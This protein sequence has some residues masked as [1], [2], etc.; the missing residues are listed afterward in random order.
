MNR[1]ETIEAIKVMQ[2]YADGGE[3][4]YRGRPGSVNTTWYSGLP[5]FNWRMNEYR[6]K[7]KL[8]E[9]QMQRMGDGRLRRPSERADGYTGKMIT[10]RE[11]L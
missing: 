7:P 4:E 5:E 10:V 1:D 9:W 3:I 6:I 11:V 2:A 8:G